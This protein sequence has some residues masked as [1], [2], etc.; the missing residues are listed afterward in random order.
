M[1]QIVA[2]HPG[3]GITVRVEYNGRIAIRLEYEK[4][5]KEAPA[6]FISRQEM[7]DLMRGREIPRPPKRNRRPFPNAVGVGR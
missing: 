4:G 3:H 2:C 5:L 7:L 1:R 6:L